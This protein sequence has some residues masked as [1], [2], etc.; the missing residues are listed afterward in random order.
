MKIPS[1]AKVASITRRLSRFLDNPAVRVREW[2]ELIA[3]EP[4]QSLWLGEEMLTRELASR[5]SIVIILIL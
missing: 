4:G 2:F 5:V 3:R 1:R